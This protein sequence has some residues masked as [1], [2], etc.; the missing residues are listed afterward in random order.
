MDA[1]DGQQ[2]LGG[3]VRLVQLPQ[4]RDATLEGVVDPV[5]ELV[6]EEQDDGHGGA[7]GEAGR[8]E[9][10]VGAEAGDEGAMNG[11]RDRRPR[12]RGPSDQTA[13]GQGVRAASS[14]ALAPAAW[15]WNAFVL[16]QPAP[17]RQTVA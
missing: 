15:I 6:G 12:K 13:E 1:E 16:A 11:A 2:N 10:R 9:R 8:K 7:G 5:A 4:R 14:F 17:P 3:V